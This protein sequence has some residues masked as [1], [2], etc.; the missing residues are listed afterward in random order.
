MHYSHRPLKH[1]VR[2]NNIL[3]FVSFVTDNIL[4]LPHVQSG[5]QVD[6]K[7]TYLRIM[8]NFFFI[9]QALQIPRL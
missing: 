8:F 6:A 9:N 7:L 1:E 3:K 5:T 2:L 4:R